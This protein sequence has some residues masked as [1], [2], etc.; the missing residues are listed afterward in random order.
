M[1]P[2]GCYAVLSE[3]VTQRG[4]LRTYSHVQI[5]S[6]PLAACFFP[7]PH[8]TRLPLFPQMFCSCQVSFIEISE[9]IMR[10]EIDVPEMNRKTLWNCCCI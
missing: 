6:P 4:S 8:T 7:P 5:A 2:Y 1:L 9:I 3:G 10:Q